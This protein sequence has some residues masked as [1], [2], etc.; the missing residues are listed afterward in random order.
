MSLF[1]TTAI[2]VALAALFAFTNARLLRLPTTIGLMVLALILSSVVLVLGQFI[3]AV[4]EA[5]ARL[6]SGIDFNEALMHGM[7]GYLLFAGALHVDLDQLRKRWA[8]VALL[9]T[10]GVALTTAI[11]GGGMYALAHLLH[12]DLP[13]IYCLLFGSLIAPTDPIAVLSILNRLGV[14][15]SLK[16][17]I[18][19]ESLFNDGVGVVVFLALLGFAHADA[20]RDAGETV[21]NPPAAVAVM[22]DTAS[23]VP[24]AGDAERDHPAQRDHELDDT[25]TVDNSTGGIVKLFAVEVGG[26]L[27]LGLLLGLLGYSMLRTVDDYKTEVLITLAIVTAGYPLA[28]AFHLSGPLAM[29]VAGLL[30]GNRGRTLAMSDQTREHLDSFWEMVD[31]LL[32]AVLFVLIGLELLI[33]PLEPTYLVAGLLAIP[34][35]LLARLI[36]VGSVKRLLEV[37]R[38][39]S[40]HTT[41]ILTWGGLRGGISVALALS[42]RQH[43]GESIGGAI[44]AM[45]YVVVLFSILVQGLT[46]GPMIRRLG[47]KGDP[48]EH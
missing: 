24:M 31:E 11:V 29:V 21:A 4:Q 34:L 37:R 23:T 17:K 44:L 8:I 47:I 33:V 30:I 32:N 6:M 9:A 48:A 45:T 19:G 36:A 35:T 12:I 15:E 42:L 25:H 7:L 39:F 16:I 5:A 20:T 10:L 13:L 2:L 14:P 38:D 27:V 3:P 26:G 41:K 46:I 18:T 22:D 43:A 1:D 40:P 28:M